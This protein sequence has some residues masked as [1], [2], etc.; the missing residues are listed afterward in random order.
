MQPSRVSVIGYVVE[1]MDVSGREVSW[2][3]HRESKAEERTSCR[4]VSGD[5]DG[6]TDRQ[7]LCLLDPSTAM[8]SVGCGR[9]LESW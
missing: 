2:S 1:V 6:V 4:W 7:F 5:D 9:G 8:V 3:W